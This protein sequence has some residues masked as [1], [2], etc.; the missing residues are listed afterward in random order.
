MAPEFRAIRLH[1][2][3][4]MTAGI[5]WNEMTVPYSNETNDEIRL[6]GVTDPVAS[7]LMRPVL[8]APGSKWY[9]NGGLT[10]VLAGIVQGM[11][12]N[13]LDRVAADVLFT[14]LGITKFE[15]LGST[16]WDPPI[17]AAMSG[18]RMR[19]RDLA[20]IGSVCLHG[21]KWKGQQIVPKEW[22]ERSMQRH[23][24]R[25]GAWSNG[26]LWGYGY[27]FWVGGFPQGYEV[28][29]ARGNGDQNVFILQREHLVVT[30]FAGAYNR[31]NGYSERI[32]H[33]IMAA[34][35]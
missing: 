5:E 16:L 33:R 3:L 1:H 14:P 30:I 12:G 22:L 23:V 34:R 8:E 32:L 21:G 20:K 24:K 29:A 15:W 6:Y 10:Q 9:Y 25:A 13:S 31:Y 4:T 35:N 11:A 28:V 2:A 27:Q 19:A 17:P 18:L 26:G 7:V